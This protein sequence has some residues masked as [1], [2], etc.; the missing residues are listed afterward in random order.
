MLRRGLPVD[1]SYSIK[2]SFLFENVYFFS[3]FFFKKGGRPWPPEPF[4][5]RRPCTKYLSIFSVPVY[6]DNLQQLN[7]EGIGGKLQRL[8][9]SFYYCLKIKTQTGNI[10]KYCSRK[11]DFLGVI[12]KSCRVLTFLFLMDYLCVYRHC[13]IAASLTCYSLPRG[14][15]SGFRFL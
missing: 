10:L 12:D 1:Y 3:F 4:L 6:C 2:D 15:N 13:L 8:K 14:L 11:E 5:L 7:V 9:L